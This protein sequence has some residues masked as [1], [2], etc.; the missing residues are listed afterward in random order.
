M[1][2]SP[3][4]TKP[5]LVVLAVNENGVAA[6]YGVNRLDRILTINKTDVRALK[7]DAMIKEID[8]AT[9][10]MVIRFLRRV[11]KEQAKAFMKI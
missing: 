1:G 3:I 5:E 9:R 8:A 10:P 7:Y 2:Q 11:D 4:T 6:R